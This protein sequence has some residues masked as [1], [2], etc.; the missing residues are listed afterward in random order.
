V[1][2]SRSPPGLGRGVTG[3]GAVPLRT[4]A[5]SEPN[6]LRRGAATTLSAS[7]GVFGFHSGGANRE[8]GSSPRRRWGG[9]TRRGLSWLAA[10]DDRPDGAGFVEPE[11]RF[12]A[13]SAADRETATPTGRT[14]GCLRP[15]RKS[16]RAGAQVWST[17]CVR[18]IA[19]YA[20]AVIGPLLMLVVVEAVQPL[21][22]RLV[23]TPFLA[24]IFLIARF[25]GFGPAMLA[26]LVSSLLLDFFVLPPV[27][28]F[29]A[30]SDGLREIILFALIAVATVALASLS[31]AD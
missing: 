27:L 13:I 11:A 25:V 28:S 10:S 4:E 24:A 14:G 23:G 3:Q 15:E 21:F 17:T 26:T 20:P 29:A 1:P 6:R 2:P 22:D 12:G 31:K 18:P 30:T 9:E 7:S 8:R 16:F 19:R 5:F